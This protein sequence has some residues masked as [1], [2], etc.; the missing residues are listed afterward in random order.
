VIANSKFGVCLVREN[1]DG[2]LYTHA[3]GQ[4]A[5]VNVDPIEKKPLYHFLPGSKSYSIGTPGCNF[6][7]GF[8]QNWQISQVSENHNQLSGYRLSPE[9]IVSEAKKNDCK[10]ISY[11]YTEPTIFFEYAYDTAG[12]AIEAGLRNVFV[13]NGY[14]SSEAVDMIQPFLHAAN[15]DLKSFRDSY[16]RKNCKARLGPVLDSVQYMKKKGIWIEITT[17]IVPGENDSDEELREISRFIT[18]VD[19]EIPWH[20][21]AFHPDYRF[22]DYPATTADTLLRAQDIGKSEGLHYV[23]PGNVFPESNTRCYNCGRLLVTRRPSVKSEMFLPD[24]HCPSCG[25]KIL[26]IWQ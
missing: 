19:I 10:S 5:A 14:I 12:L 23:Y 4:A 2:T 18:G 8:C 1:I 16:Y 24:T 26:G 6:K 25:A 3:Y 13:T 21:T 20:V 11:T 7:C 9:E 17:L 15:I 22:T